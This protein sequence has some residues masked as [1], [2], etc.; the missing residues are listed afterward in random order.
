[1]QLTARFG[2]GTGP[3][4]RIDDNFGDKVVTDDIQHW[5]KIYE[6]VWTHHVCL[7]MAFRLSVGIQISTGTELTTSITE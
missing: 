4:T 5:V 7:A 6:S 3:T 2:T 1:M